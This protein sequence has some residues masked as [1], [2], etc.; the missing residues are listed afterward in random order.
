MQGEIGRQ[1]SSQDPIFIVGCPRSGNTLLG[2][3]LN[4]HPD[5]FVLF[6]IN[7]FSE[8]YR[9][10]ISR[11]GPPDERFVRIVG[12]TLSSLNSRF[13]VSH[14]ELISCALD[15]GPQWAAMLD[16]YMKMLIARAKPD[17]R[18]WGDKTPHHVSNLSHIHQQYP[19]AQFI[20]TYRDPRRVV[21]SLSAPTFRPAFNNHYLNAALVR[22]YLTVYEKQKRLVD[23]GAIREVCYEAL[24]AD[25]ESVV[26]DLCDFL[27]VDYGSELLEGADAGIRQMIGWPTYKGWGKIVPQAGRQSE[28]AGEWIAAYLNDWIAELGYEQESIALRRFKRAAVALRTLPFQIARRVLSS[29]WR[30]RYPNFPF[31]MRKYPTIRTLLRS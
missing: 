26:R 7:T 4:K 19:N 15:S 6:E 8:L 9:K 30:T 24:V 13:D 3:I 11:E 16:A 23:Q 12:E 5:L 22:H 27:E 10:W 31:L 25:P 29:M 1:V 2:A 18:R 28:G 17:A 21:V 14:T 20:Y